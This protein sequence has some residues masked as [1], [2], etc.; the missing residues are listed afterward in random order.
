MSTT[1]KIPIW[2]DCDPGHDDAIAILMALHLPEIDLIGISTVHGNAPLSATTVNAA[3]CLLSFGS[4]EQAKRIPIYEGA[5]KPLI[6][7]VKHDDEIHGSDGLGGVEG[8][9]P[10]DDPA[11]VA[12]LKE[13]EGQT[14]VLALAKAASSLPEGE[15]LTIV[16]TGA[17]TNIALFISLFPQLVATKIREIVVMGGAEGRGNRSP[18]AEFNAMID[19]H[20]TSIVFDAEVPVAMA[21]L[22]V[23]HQAL[24]RPSD[25]STLLLPP[26]ALPSLPSTTAD[27]TS[28]PS[29]KAHTPLRHTLSTLLNFFA[30]TYASVFSFTDGPPVHDPLCVAYLAH[31]EIFRGKRYRVDV[32]L[33]GKF[34]Q[35]STVV[36]LY[37]YR[38]EELVD[39][40]EDKEG[41]KGWGKLGKNVHVLEELDVPAFWALFQQC[42]D[43]ADKVSP[44]NAKQ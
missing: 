4:P 38:E 31:P 11:V 27:A 2:L 22:N 10:H 34:T 7:V 40:K 9:L 16:A 30:S 39:W 6:R 1:A 21:P 37:N 14:A 15:Q 24:F 12:K 42:V 29:T 8:L 44:L 5:S 20:A 28:S 32:E 13:T 3:R 36:D 19:C 33:E 25:N 23:T 43:A 17:F 35:G 18:T 41:R 26:S